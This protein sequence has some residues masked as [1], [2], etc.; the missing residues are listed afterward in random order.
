MT[1][2][3]LSAHCTSVNT[4]QAPALTGN[5]TGDRLVRGLTLDE[6]ATRA[7]PSLLLWVR[8]IWVALPALTVRRWARRLS[9]RSLGVLVC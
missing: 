6:R 5:R 3:L 9:P 1:L 7:G 4:H 2:S 8:C